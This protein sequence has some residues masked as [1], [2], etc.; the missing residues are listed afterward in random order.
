MCPQN[1]VP[2]SFTFKVNPR[3]YAPYQSLWSPGGVKG[4]QFSLANTLYASPHWNIWIVGEKQ[5]IVTQV[6]DPRRS[7]SRRTIA[8]K[9][10]HILRGGVSI[11]KGTW[12]CS[13]LVMYTMT[14]SHCQASQN[15]IWVTGGQILE[16]LLL[17]RGPKSPKKSYLIHQKS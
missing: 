5:G 12:P 8:P 16:G 10:C 11:Q 3:P 15:G 2:Q 1:R 14:L 6:S 7:N 4:A 9:R 17:P 13:G